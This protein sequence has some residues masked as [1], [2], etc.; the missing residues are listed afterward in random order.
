MSKQGDGVAPYDHH[1]AAVRPPKS[2]SSHATKMYGGKYSK[3]AKACKLKRLGR[4]SLKVMHHLKLV[5]KLESDFNG[6][7]TH[8]RL[9]YD[10]QSFLGWCE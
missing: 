8:A 5:L 4:L 9:A 7:A 2:L 6:L 1:E 3:A 10:V